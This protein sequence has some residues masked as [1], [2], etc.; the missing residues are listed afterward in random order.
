MVSLMQIID[1]HTHVFPDDLAPRAREALIVPGRHQ[2]HYDATLVGLL[3]TMDKN[4]IDRSWTVPVAT[5]P[6]QVES[7]NKFAAS[8]P[9]DRITPFGGIHPDLDDAYEVLSTF[10][11]L[12]LSGFK[13][14]PDYQGVSPDD[15]R[16]QPI[17][18]AAMDFGL[19]AFFHAG[20]DVGPRTKYG[21]PRVFSG[22]LDEHPTMKLVLAH[23]GGYDAW[24]GVDELLIGRDVYLDTAYTFGHLEMDRFLDMANRHGWNRIMFGTDGPWTDAT[25]ELATIA[26]LELPDS[27]LS[28][29]LY[30]NAERMLAS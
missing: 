9:R 14:H 2:A 15:P 23:F 8:Q 19:I 21:T 24:D 29:L 28:D 11:S 13:I 6:N 17:Y 10:P 1:V 12:G 26:S 16:M 5:K 4:G 7:I 22:I 3:D 27:D 20:D 18:D 30:R 25:K